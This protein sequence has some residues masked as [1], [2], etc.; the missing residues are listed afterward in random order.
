MCKFRQYTLGHRI[1]N[2]LHAPNFRPD[3]GCRVM[4]ITGSKLGT[5]RRAYLDIIVINHSFIKNAFAPRRIRKC[6]ARQQSKRKLFGSVAAAS[7][8]PGSLWSFHPT[9]VNVNCRRA[10]PRTL[11][12]VGYTV[13]ARC[14]DVVQSVTGWYLGLDSS[15]IKRR[16]IF[17]RVPYWCFSACG[18]WYKDSRCELTVPSKFV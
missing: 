16:A 4:D 15:I 8:S 11:T 17:L 2:T 12:C 6:F 13:L 7:L 1:I 18:E 9:S 5:L 14:S 3:K 10:S